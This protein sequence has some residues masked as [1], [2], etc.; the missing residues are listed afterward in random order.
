MD[1]L[2]TVRLGIVSF[3]AKPPRVV[4]K[5]QNRLGLVNGDE[6]SIHHDGHRTSDFTDSVYFW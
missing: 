3:C 5:E 2:C 6:L 4:N 1:V